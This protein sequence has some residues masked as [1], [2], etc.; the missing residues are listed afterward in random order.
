MDSC[1]AFVYQY[2]F[3]FSFLYNNNLFWAIHNSHKKYRL[4]CQ[5]L[6]SSKSLASKPTTQNL[7]TCASRNSK[8]NV[9][10]SF[11]HF[12][13]VIPHWLIYAN[14]LLSIYLLSPSENFSPILHLYLQQCKISTFLG[15]VSLFSGESPQP[16]LFLFSLSLCFFH[17]PIAVI[18]YFYLIYQAFVARFW[19]QRSATGVCFVRGCQKLPPCLTEQCQPDPRQICCCQKPR[20]SEMVVMSL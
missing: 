18:V 13:L 14:L 10:Q 12:I 7:P 11:L 20:Q 8:S 2:R 5:P 16:F 19:Q 3:S 9:Q 17:P 1:H 4:R 15:P 6:F